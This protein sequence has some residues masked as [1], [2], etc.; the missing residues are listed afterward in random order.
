MQI[1][2]LHKNSDFLGIVSA[3]LCLIHCIALPVFLL[4][5][6]SAGLVLSNWHWLDFIFI[7]LACVAVY[8]STKKT[9]SAL[10]KTGMW[11]SVTIF[12]IAL[13]SHEISVYAQY[14]SIAASV[15]LMMLHFINIRHCRR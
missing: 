1:K 15:A 9:A 3:G 8:F 5:T 4:G 6:L 7:A 2:S 14:I 12:A 11:A 10:I 13:L